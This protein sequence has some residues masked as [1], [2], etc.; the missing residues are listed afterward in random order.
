M[1]PKALLGERVSHEYSGPTW[2]LYDDLASRVGFAEGVRTEWIYTNSYLNN[3][4][5]IIVTYR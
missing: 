4:Y 2:K 3:I 5:I 1:A